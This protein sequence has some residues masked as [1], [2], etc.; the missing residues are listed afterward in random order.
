VATYE[1]I[2]FETLRHSTTVEAD[3]REDALAKGHNVIMNYD[4]SH[5]ITESNGTTAVDAYLTSE[6]IG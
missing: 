3:N 6:V 2:V 5:F 4:E 1:V